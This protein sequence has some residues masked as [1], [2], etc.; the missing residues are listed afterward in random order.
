MSDNN[1]DEKKL[2][3]KK[4]YNKKSYGVPK[5]WVGKE[6]ELGNNVYVYGEVYQSEL[7]ITTTEEIVECV[8]KKHSRYVQLLV[9]K[10]IELQLERTRRT[11][12]G[13]EGETSVSGEDEEV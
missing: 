1:N 5:H 9:G 6:K 2:K 11:K 8:G 13:R 12:T 10:G 4:S 7:Y 3:K